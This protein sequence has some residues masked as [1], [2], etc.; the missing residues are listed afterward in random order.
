MTLRRYAPMK[1]SMG[2][3]IPTAMKLEVYDRDQGCVGPRVGMPCDCGG[4]LEPD[5][6]R[7]SHGTGMKSDTETWNLVALCSMHHRMKTEAGKTWR[8]VLL[9]Y[10]ASVEDPHAAHVDPCGP[11]CR[12]AVGS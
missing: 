8:P 7:A 9:D 2:T 5:H 3:V 6:V 11:A 12:A 1:R 4:Q 10:L